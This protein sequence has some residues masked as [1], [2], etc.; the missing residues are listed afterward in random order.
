ME[1]YKQEDEVE[2]VDLQDYI[3]SGEP[4]PKRAKYYLISVDGEKERVRSPITTREILIIF[5]LDPDDYCLE[6]VLRGGKS[7]PLEFDEVI[8][9]RERGI[10][11]FVSK[12]KHVVKIFV[13]SRE[14]EVK[15]GMAKQMLMEGESEAKISRYTGL[16]L[17]TIQALKK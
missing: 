14:K 15:K 9:L 17:A 5:D 2:V 13:N 4:I 16:P 6:Q 12:V 10:E 11:R 7:L 1:N 8:D 3:C